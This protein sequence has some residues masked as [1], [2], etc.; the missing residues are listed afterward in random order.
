MP[1]FTLIA[2]HTDLYGKPD[3]TK[4]NY[5]FYVDTLDN[6]LEHVDLFI[7]GC[8]Y[9]PTG[10]LDYVTDEEY[11]GTPEW[12]NEEFETPMGTKYNPDQNSVVHSAYF[13]DTE[14]NK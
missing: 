7:R 3:G 5:E 4:V 10:Q 14:R 6:V 8:G 1:K 9:N 12:Y 2:E 13:F 11:Y